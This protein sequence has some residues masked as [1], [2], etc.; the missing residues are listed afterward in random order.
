MTQS[1]LPVFNPSF[2]A[3]KIILIRVD[4]NVPI[5]D[6]VVLDTNRIEKILP[7]IQVLSKNGAK[8][9]LM[10]HLGR[11]KGKPDD[12]FSLKVLI[13]SLSQFLQQP[14]LFVNDVI[15]PKT[16]EAITAMKPGQVLLLEN[17]RFHLGEE[18]NDEAFAQQLAALGDIYIN[19]GFAVSHRA[20]ASVH[21]ITHYMPSYAGL[22]MQDEITALSQ[23]FIHPK[24]PVMAIIGG[25]KVSSKLD[26]L[27]NL[28]AKV[29]YLV[30]GGGIANTFL[31]VDGHDVGAS[32][33]EKE[34][35]TSVHA[36]QEAAKQSG[37]TIITPSDV[38][39]AT[40]PSS[41]VKETAI[42]DIA[43]D[44]K[45]FDIGP[46]TV[47]A[48][49]QALAKC[50][51]VVWN[52]PLGLFETPPFDEGTTAV[53]KLIATNEHLYSLA[54]GGETVAALNQSGTADKF[55]YLSTGGGAF[56]E[57]LEGKQLPGIQALMQKT[58]HDCPQNNCHSL[59]KNG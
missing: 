59:M 47:A 53:A 28:V 54:G 52:G 16:K 30:V 25:A 34:M 51:T 56:L 15:G 10:A 31:F 45:I 1:S 4:L 2:C 40:D 50:Q 22:L 3:N 32:L 9:V 12:S 46:Q 42:T 58:E 6:G 41:T 37:C 48:I 36:I 18:E 23:A 49:G 39:V 8:V 7:T 29:D 11:P 13:P 19:E 55:S 43:A 44:E 14:V 35:I 27:K 20:H 5:K 33:C 26:L 17:L 21:A 57:F 24:R 38:I